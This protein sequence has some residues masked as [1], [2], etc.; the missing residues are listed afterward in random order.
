MG[1]TVELAMMAKARVSQLGGYEISRGVPGPHLGDWP[2]TL[3]EQHSIAVSGG[4]GAGEL[5]L[6]T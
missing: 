6:R 2:L 4:L 3:T 5:V 1:N